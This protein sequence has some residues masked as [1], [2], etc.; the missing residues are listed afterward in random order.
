MSACMTD[1]RRRQVHARGSHYKR[2]SLAP[3]AC[4]WL[5]EC[6]CVLWISFFCSGKCKAAILLT[7]SKDRSQKEVNRIDGSSFPCWG[8]TLALP[9]LMFYVPSMSRFPH[10]LNAGLYMESTMQHFMAIFL[11][12]GSPSGGAA[13]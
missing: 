2:H 6:M 7:N 13:R 3:T 8:V 5:A 12:S 11:Y 9:K 1:S 4:A 10:L